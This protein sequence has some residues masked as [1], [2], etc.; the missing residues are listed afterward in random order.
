MVPQFPR[1][2]CLVQI[3]V[4]FSLFQITEKM[5]SFDTTLL[6]Q[7]ASVAIP[8]AILTNTVPSEPPTSK[9]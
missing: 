7:L 5:Y 2:T 9:V 8:A 4:A 1:M 6:F 3:P